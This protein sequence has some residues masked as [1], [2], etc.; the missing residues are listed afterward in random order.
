M[1][2]IIVRDGTAILY[3][4]F[5][6]QP[7]KP[8]DVVLLGANV[9]CGSEPEGHVTV[10]TVYLDTD[11]VLDQLFWQ[12][13]QILADRH[14]AP[15][16][17][18][19]LYTEPAQVLRLGEDLTGMMMPWLDE[20]VRLS[21][22]GGFTKQFHRMQALWFMTVDVIAPHIRISPERLSPTQRARSRPSLPRH[23][24]FAPLRAEVR[25]IADLLQDEFARPWTLGELAARVH[26]SASQFG[27]VFADAYGLTPLAYQRM[28]RAQRLAELLRTTDLSVE[29]AMRQVGWHSRGHAARL[30]R[31]HVGLSP[32]EYRKRSRGRR[33]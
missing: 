29:T 4:E 24:C 5:G 33:T 8:G 11:Y 22:D 32:S 13:S 7:I 20:L 6:E 3:S 27:R 17:A 18:Q 31:Q 26:M 2:F 25:K 12:H 30:F 1:K 10:T 14:E 15:K 16:L 19:V 23:R 28:L 9:L 21:I